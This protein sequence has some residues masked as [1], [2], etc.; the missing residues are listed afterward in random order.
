VHRWV[1]YDS[2]VAEL[3][4]VDPARRLPVFLT[5]QDGEGLSLSIADLRRLFL[6][7]W[8]DGDH[9]T[10]YD[11]QVTA[12]LRWI[13]PVR[14]VESYLSGN[15]IIYRGADGSDEGIRWSL[16]QAEAR[17]IWGDKLVRGEVESNEVL[18]HFT[19]DG[20]NL[21]IVDPEDIYDVRPV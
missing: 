1:D 20:K 3:E 9:P 8:G 16:D 21:V 4:T 11:N 10:E 13:A 7:V 15:H 19:A 18:A 12:L 6:Y 5:E 17:R 14:D 2:A